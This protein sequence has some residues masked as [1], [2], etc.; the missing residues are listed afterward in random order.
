M[1]IKF[2]KYQG[3]GNDFVIIDQRKEQYLTPDDRTQISRFCDRRFGIGADGLMCIESSKH[4]AFRMVYFNS[5][6]RESTM[7]GNGG[8][9]IVALAARLGIF[10]GNKCGFEA[11]DGYHEATILNDGR[12]SLKMKD[13]GAI[14]RLDEAYTLDTGSPHFVEMVTDLDQTD[15]VADGRAIR[16]DDLFMPEG[17]NVNFVEKKNGVL[18]IRTYERGVEDE[19]YACGTGVV[20]ASLV[21]SL[22]D[23]VFA[24]N[25]YIVKAKGGDLSVSF[26]RFYDQFRNIVLTGPAEFVYKGTIQL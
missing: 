9:C 5:D 24:K 16:Y 10:Q 2:Y 13:V 8:R 12:V 25:E 11:I 6:G 14:H 18:Y 15:V 21:A 22:K 23:D 1:E 3:A 26:E 4:H 7:C 17:I 20:A 19:T